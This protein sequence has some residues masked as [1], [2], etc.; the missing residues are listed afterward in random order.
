MQQTCR[1]AWCTKPFEVTD[2]DLAFLEK[3]S[4]AFNGKKEQIPPPT[5]CPD[6][7][8]RRRQCWRNERTLYQRTNSLDG[9]P[10]VSIHSPD[11]PYPVYPNE[12]WWGDG[13]DAKQYGRP[14]DFTRP[15]FEQ[16]LELRNDVP[17][18]ARS[19][20]QPTM[21]NSDFCNE[22]GDLKNCY[23]C[24]ESALCEDC[25]YSR[26]LI[27]C[28]DCLDCLNSTDCT[29]CYQVIDSLNCYNATE[30]LNCE[31][32]SDCHFCKDCVGCT[33]CLF[34]EHLRNKRFCIRNAQYE[35]G[36]Y[37]RRA[38]EILAHRR[39]SSGEF[40]RPQER[41][42]RAV[43]MTNVENCTGD[44]LVNCKNCEHCFS[45]AESE[46]LKYCDSL[47]AGARN[48]D[49]M[50]VTHF[51]MGA[52]LS[53]ECQCIGGNP[54]SG[55]HVLFSSTCW[56]VSDLLYCYYCPSNTRDCF[57]CVGLRHAQYCILNK[58]YTKEEYEELVPR[59]IEHMRKTDEWGEFFPPEHSPFGYNETVVQEF[60]PLSR[61][62]ALAQGWLWCD[63]VSPPPQ[64]TKVIDGTA[65]PDSIKDV[66]DEILDHAIRCPVTGKAFKIIRQELDF[67]R[68]KSIPLPVFHPDERYR[69]RMLFRNPRKL[70]IRECAKCG[71]G[72]QT[73]YAPDRPEIVYCEQCYLET[74]Y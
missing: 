22:A 65:L 16:F 15:F 36:E 34:S 53:Y 71:K 29:L 32:C 18:P 8:Q 17:M 9:S 68:S 7:R 24:F 52:Q 41:I 73:S 21:F 1:N 23:L 42:A 14:F 5:R 19:C 33:D 6:C 48:Y 35:E 69:Q 4:P 70:W 63:Y 72:I 27:Q 49:C 66:T 30:L 12:E 59:I 74:V 61:E 25:L 31:R 40:C 55:F 43:H 39:E 3:I 54:N 60:T 10:V 56:S 62:D 44:F 38:A 50:D 13:W 2:G 37:R 45:C 51:G 67:Y 47:L 26:G 46:D 58:Q 57:G 11:K 64:S 20:E 28:K